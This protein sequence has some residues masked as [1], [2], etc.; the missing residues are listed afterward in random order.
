MNRL[1]TGAC[2]VFAAAA[3]L[4]GYLAFGTGSVTADESGRAQSVTWTNDVDLGLPVMRTTVTTDNAVDV[5]VVTTITRTADGSL[6]SKMDNGTGT[7][8]ELGEPGAPAI[9]DEI[10]LSLVHDPS[11]TSYNIV[12]QFYDMS[13]TLVAT[14]SMSWTKP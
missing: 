10:N 13:D 3:V 7:M 2:V 9:A 5:R 12:S 14:K 8:A 4:A 1:Q 6:V 11:G